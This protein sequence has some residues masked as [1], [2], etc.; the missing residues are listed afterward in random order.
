[1]TFCHA[2]PCK[3]RL[4]LGVVVDNGVRCFHLLAHSSQHQTALHF[5]SGHVQ[6]EKRGEVRLLYDWRSVN[7]YVLVSS[8]LVGLA[9]R[10]YFLSKGCCLVSVGRPLWREDGSAICSVITQC[11]ESRR[12]RNHTLLSHLRLLQPGGPGSR[13]YNPQEQGGPVIPPGTGFP[14][15]ACV[16]YVLK[17]GLPRSNVRNCWNQVPWIPRPNTIQKCHCSQLEQL[18]W[19]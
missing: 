6:D 19:S 16:C 13:I 14:L 3:M 18:L 1:M 8:T 10:Y 9:T 12:T 15:H 17:S 7:Q 5:R 4:S 2:L 11:S